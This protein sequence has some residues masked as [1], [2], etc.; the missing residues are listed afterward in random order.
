MNKFSINLVGKR[1]IFKRFSHEMRAARKRVG[2]E[3]YSMYVHAFGVEPPMAFN[4]RFVF[5]VFFII[6]Y[7]R[8]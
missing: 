2:L 7:I 8:F 3:I 4:C 1:C 5:L 6:S